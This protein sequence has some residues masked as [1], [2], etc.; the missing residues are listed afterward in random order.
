VS[1]VDPTVT[2]TTRKED[3]AVV[4]D[5]ED[6]VAMADLR[7]LGD[8]PIVLEGSSAAI[9]RLLVDGRT[10]DDLVSDLAELFQVDH[11][12]VRSQVADFVEELA[13][14]GLVAPV[15]DGALPTGRLEP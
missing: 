15:V 9:W 10:L 4:D 1:P 5:G 7:R 8:P 12:A 13:T 2:W 3:L 14:R 11:A 6:R